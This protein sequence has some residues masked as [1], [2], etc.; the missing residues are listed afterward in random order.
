MGL[1]IAHRAVQAHGGALLVSSTP[2]HGATFAI[3]LP[4][5]DWDERED[6]ERKGWSELVAG[7]AQDGARY[8]HERFDGDGYPTGLEGKGIPL[9][10]RVIAVADTYDAMTSS[11]S[12]RPAMSHD[13]AIAE[14][15]R[16]S[17]RQLDPEVVNAFQSWCQADP[18]WLRRITFQDEFTG[19]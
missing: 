1:A 13:D 18:D 2:G 8:H 11:R 19:G 5:R 4:R 17:G 16:V 14:I 3:I 12:Y 10:A 9:A 15:A 6:L 7:S